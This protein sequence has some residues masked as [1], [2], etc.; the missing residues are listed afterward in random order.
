MALIYNTPLNEDY[1]NPSL[2]IEKRVESIGDNLSLLSSE[3]ELH[4]NEL[5]FVKRGISQ[6]ASKYYNNANSL[7]RQNLIES[8]QEMEWSFVTDNITGFCSAVYRQLEVFTNFI[9]FEIKKC[10]DNI[11]ID[12]ETQKPVVLPNHFINS[13]TGWF[14]YDS[15]AKSNV[16]VDFKKSKDKE[17]YIEPYYLKTTINSGKGV[18]N[19][20]FPNKLNLIF[21][22]Y[23]NKKIKH[24]DGIEYILVNNGYSELTQRIKDIRDAKE[25]GIVSKHLSS[26]QAKDYYES[27]KVLNEL[28]QRIPDLK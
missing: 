6:K 8:M 2:A 14:V 23:I 27:M 16:F 26:W 28:F 13:F 11:N 5:Y 24:S 25:H 17:N 9:L 18:L 22:L 19:I 21:G 12:A 1:K 7:I 3:L 20:S 15:K 10:N 4:Q